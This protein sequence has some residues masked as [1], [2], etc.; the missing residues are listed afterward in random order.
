MIAIGTNSIDVHAL[1]VQEACRR[2]Q[3]DVQL[4]C[5][6]CFLGDETPSLRF[7]RDETWTFGRGRERAYAPDVKTVW[8]RR[9]EYA[10]LPRDP[11]P[12]EVREKSFLDSFWRTFA[13]DAFWIN[14]IESTTRGLSKILQERIVRR[15]G[16]KMPRTLYS[17]DPVAIREFLHQEKA[18]IYKPFL[19]KRF[20]R[21]DGKKAATFAAVFTEETIPAD[22]VIRLC[23]GIYQSYVPKN[24]ELRV[25]VMGDHLFAA[26]IRS[27]ETK[28]GALDWRAAYG[29]FRMERHS[30]DPYVATRLRELM[31]QLEIVFGCFDL[32]VT[33]DGDHVFLEVN[34]RGNWLFVEEQ[35]GMPLL[36]AFCE[37]LRQGREDFEWSESDSS[38]RLKHLTSTLDEQIERA[39]RVFCVARLS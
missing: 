35:T 10:H 24:Y 33:P 13:S 25:T 34:V 26:K 11:S 2:K 29:E 23:P 3:I 5:R 4:I 21:E 6:C 38:I 28:H 15:V 7:D 27:Q 36:D 30:L 31:K 8:Y 37:F 14:S 1:A 17:N 12:E 19:G 39:K 9:P 32:I 16:L 20:T 22:E 18:L